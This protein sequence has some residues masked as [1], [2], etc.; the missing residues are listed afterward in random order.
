MITETTNSTASVNPV[1]DIADLLISGLQTDNDDKNQESTNTNNTNEGDTGTSNEEGQ[2]GESENED[3]TNSETEEGTNEGTDDGEVT[4]SGVLGVEDENVVLDEEG[5]LQGLVVK[6]DGVTSTVSVK[7]LI[8][9]YQ[10]NKHYTQKSQALAEER[11]DFER[12]RGEVAQS[13][14]EKLG[15]VEKLTGFLYDSMTKEF[16]NINWEKLRAENPGEYAAAVADYQTRDAQFKQILDAVHAENATLA[17][18]HQQEQGVNYQKHLA[19]QYEK[20]LLNNPS[21]RDVK[22][23]QSDLMEMGSEASDLYGISSNEFQYLNDA[24]HIEI[25]KDALAFRKGKT[26]AENKLKTVPPKFQKASGGKS[27]KPM[28]KLTRLTL[29]ARKAS[30]SKQRDLQTAAVAELLMGGR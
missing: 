1:S 4:W 18:Q 6:V 27:G 30:G 21:W 12:V 16:Q 29:D 5:N 11:R 20:V 14:T 19:E 13:Y 22:K 28:S 23:M 25:L 26:I 17:Q 9:G 15:A 10:T 2:S 8:A 3:S 24:R 7:D